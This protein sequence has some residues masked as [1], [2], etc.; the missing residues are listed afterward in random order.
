NTWVPKLMGQL[1][2]APDLENVS[3]N[4]LDRGLSIN[5]TMDRD[6]AARFGISPA[7]IDNA[8]Y[9]AFGQRIVST[10][11][12]ESNQYRVILEASPKLQ[13]SINSLSAIY[14]PSSAQTQVPL[15]AVAKVDV[16]PVPLEIDHLAQYPSA[17]VSFDVAA[18]AS[19]G[20]AV[21]AVQQAETNI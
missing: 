11:F 2:Q 3:T 15:D 5:M 7:T 18:N 6:T 10:I 19:L 1:Q 14:L 9:D 8:L 17:T 4:Y 13:N 12:T 21:D 16:Q 20:A